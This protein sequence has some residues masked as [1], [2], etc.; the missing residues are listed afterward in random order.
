MYSTKILSYTDNNIT[1]LIPP[2]HHHYS[3]SI[4]HLLECKSLQSLDVT[5]NRLACDEDNLKVLTTIP[6]LTNISINGKC[7][8]V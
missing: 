1:L 5:N 3:D 6:R 4:S 7:S 2:H 8:V